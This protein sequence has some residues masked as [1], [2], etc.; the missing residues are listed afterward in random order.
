MSKVRDDIRFIVYEN[1]QGEPAWNYHK[2]FRMNVKLD[3]IATSSEQSRPGSYA[4]QFQ[5]DTCI[6]RIGNTGACQTLMCLLYFILFFVGFKSEL[7]GLLRFPVSVWKVARCRKN[8]D[9]AV[10]LLLDIIDPLRINR[11]IYPLSNLLMAF[12]YAAFRAIYHLGSLL[13]F[14]SQIN[15][16]NLDFARSY[17][18]SACDLELA[19]NAWKTSEL[20]EIFPTFRNFR[21]A[22]VWAMPKRVFPK[23]SGYSFLRG[24][25]FL[26]MKNYL[27]CPHPRYSALEVLQ[28]GFQDALFNPEE[29]AFGRRIMFISNVMLWSFLFLVTEEFSDFCWIARTVK[30]GAQ[31]L[32]H[33][34]PAFVA[35]LISS[36]VMLNTRYGSF[37]FQFRTLQDGILSVV[38]WALGSPIT[39]MENNVDYLTD[40]A[41]VGLA[42]F[43]IFLTIFVVVVAANIFVAVVMEAYVVAIDDKT[44]YKGDKSYYFIVNE[45][46]RTFAAH[47]WF[48]R[49]FPNVWIPNTFSAKPQG[50]LMVFKKAATLLDE[51][52]GWEYANHRLSKKPGLSRQNSQGASMPG[53]RLGRQRSQNR[54]STISTTQ[55]A[56]LGR[57]RSQNIEEEED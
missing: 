14:L 51:E 9:D 2:Y 52:K 22:S 35:I 33:F 10:A 55:P 19:A 16:C 5:Y 44:L 13:N 36:A 29:D 56:R 20:R 31:Q 21:P 57:Q 1:E 45:T 3:L 26:V 41:S 8:Q 32:Q 4:S 27:T 18:Y 15:S 28:A 6:F 50:A 37:F 12:L 40:Q 34:L 11:D 53:F 23:Y 17:P 7:V 49:L 38:G 42:F 24:S 47:L 25:Q 48:R 54:D 43:V 46:K 30:R 39:K